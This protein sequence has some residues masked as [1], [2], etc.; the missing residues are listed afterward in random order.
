MFRI[1]K[2]YRDAASYYRNR[3]KISTK[4]ELKSHVFFELLENFDA[5]LIKLNDLVET[6][7][8]NGF[9]KGAN[10]AQSKFTI[11]YYIKNYKKF[12]F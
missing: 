12:D 1:I 6:D 9:W 8:G 11:Q 10:N 5:C 7:Y 3:V 4:S 2:E